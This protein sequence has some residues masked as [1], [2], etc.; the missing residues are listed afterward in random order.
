MK[1]IIAGCLLCFN[2]TALAAEPNSLKSGHFMIYNKSNKTITLGVGNFFPEKHTIPPG[3][4]DWVYV[5]S[6]NQN[7]TVY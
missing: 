4:K 2:L 7:I 6:D 5:T 3:G 1:K